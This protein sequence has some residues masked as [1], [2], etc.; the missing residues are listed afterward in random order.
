MSI[1]AHGNNKRRNILALGKDFIE[2]IDGT[3]IYAEKMYSITF[4]NSK[5]RFF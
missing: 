3:T 2:G 5:T 4:T 1:S